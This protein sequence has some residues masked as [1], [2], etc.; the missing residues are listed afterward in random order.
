MHARCAIV[1]MIPWY[2]CTRVNITQLHY[3][4]CNIL[5]NVNSTLYIVQC[6]MYNVQCTW[7]IVYY[8][9]SLYCISYITEKTYIHQHIHTRTNK[10]I[11]EYIH[12]QDF[13]SIIKKKFLAKNLS[14]TI[15]YCTHTH[16][17]AHTRTHTRTYTHIHSYICAQ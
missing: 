10:H 15:L 7:Y 9:C 13:R 11:H 17:H 12:T 2:V 4:I 8:T 14:H 16:T 5:Y 1:N 6:T 3:F